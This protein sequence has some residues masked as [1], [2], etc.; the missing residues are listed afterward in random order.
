MTINIHY[1]IIE[2]WP[3]EHLIVARYWTDNVSEESLAVDQNRYPDGTPVRCRSDV[4]ISLPVPA[5]DGDDL[6]K[7]IMYNA[8]LVWLKTLEAVKDPD[9][10]TN[11]DN[12]TSL[13]GKVKT[14]TEDEINPKPVIINDSEIDSLLKAL[15]N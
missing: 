1:K 12:I 7:L 9:I 4:S 13:I 11:I 15:K 10:N 8:P 14:S 6:D 3:N 2:T 5:P